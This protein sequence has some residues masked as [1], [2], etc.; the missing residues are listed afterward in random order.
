MKREKVV[1][2]RRVKMT[3]HLHK[4]KRKREKKTKRNQRKKMTKY[5]TRKMIS[6]MKSQIQQHK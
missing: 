2:R 3:R 4:R 1:N 6:S 5:T